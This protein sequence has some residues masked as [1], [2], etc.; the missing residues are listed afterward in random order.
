MNHHADK[1][2][3]GDVEVE[4]EELYACP[5]C[6]A[7]ASRRVIASPAPARRSTS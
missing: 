7:A 1:P 2:V 3:R 6:G 5:D 4:L